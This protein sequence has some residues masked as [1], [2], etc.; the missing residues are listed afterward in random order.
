MHRYRSPTL[1]IN[2]STGPPPPAV[3]MD[4]ET[5]TV[6]NTETFPDVADSEPVT[7][8]DAVTV[9]PLISFPGPAASFST[10]TLGFNGQSGVQPL[11]VS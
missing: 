9:T 2:S 7:V 4:N 5:I 1:T 3:V 8:T 10:A 11:S 6:T